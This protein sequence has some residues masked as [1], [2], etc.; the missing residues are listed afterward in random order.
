MTISHLSMEKICTIDGFN[1]LSSF[2]VAL[3]FK[4]NSGIILRSDDHACSRPTN[5][6]KDGCVELIESHA[7]KLLLYAVYIVFGI[8][9]V[10]PCTI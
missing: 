3:D 8:A 7:K 6:T 4:M 5:M 9:W 2:N 10:R 1:I